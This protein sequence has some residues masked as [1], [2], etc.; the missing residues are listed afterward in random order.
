MTPTRRRLRAL[1]RAYRGRGERRSA[2]DTAYNL[3]LAALMAPLVAFPIVRAVVLALIAPPT[4]AA[5]VGPS[6]VAV[7][8]V[9][10]GLTL[11][12]LA[13]LGVLYGPVS[14]EPAF[15]RLLADTDLPRHATLARPFATK[16]AIAVGALLAVAVL[17][18]GVLLGAGVATLAGAA[19]LA[20]LCAAFGAI[21]AVTWLAG[22]AAS[23]RASGVVGAVIAVLA[24]L[25]LAFPGLGA[26]LPWG[27][28]A[29]TWPPAAAPFALTDVLLV[30]LAA[31]AIAGARP[32]LDLLRS[33][34]LADDAARW[35]AAGTA[36]LSGD[37][38]HALGGLRARP[39]AG[40]R[41][42]AVRGGPAAAMFLARDLVGAARTPVRLAVGI[43]ALAG[44]VVLL[45]VAT[46]LPAGWVLAAVGAG[47]AYLALGVL[48]DG[49]RHATDAAVAPP[50]YGYSTLALFARHGLAPLAVAVA[51]S[52][53]GIGGAAVLGVG[54]RPLPVCVVL[55]VVVLVR[56]Y[57]SAK[58]PLPVLLLTPIPS[59]IGDLSS[60][61]VSLWQ[62]DALLIAVVV[63][64]LA[65][66]AAPGSPL[67][68]VVLAVVIAGLLVVGLRRRLRQL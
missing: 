65:V 28:V 16:A 56:A 14:L 55:L 61:N 29:A 27:W 15:V 67:G 6:S 1:R 33:S 8:G 13:W 58:G 41:W 49:F 47:L 34:R 17:F 50:L 4:L 46:S 9:V 24:A 5:L 35:R 12:G 42:H 60:L 44:S 30:L 7:V 38:A 54:V 22:Q 57:D 10:L 37:V 26:V 20:V 64:A 45:A 66:A 39:S 11:A 31:A 18:G 3:Y 53:A 40:R 43:L 2:S 21:G 23:P 25:G 62:A 63:G 36:A 19:R 68:M 32:L 52:V 51:A 59:P 48:T